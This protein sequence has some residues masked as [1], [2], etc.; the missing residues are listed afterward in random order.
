MS[1]HGATDPTDVPTSGPPASPD[2]WAETMAATHGYAD[3]S[4]TLELFGTC[5]RC[6]RQS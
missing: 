1:L 4:H 2:L 6:Q 3:L 5:A